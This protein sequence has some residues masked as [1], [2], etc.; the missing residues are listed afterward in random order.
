MKLSFSTLMCMN[1]NASQLL[2]LINTTGMDAAEIRTN[3]DG[4]FVYLPDLPV[5]DIASGINVTGYS[6]SALKTA[7]N[8]LHKID[9]TN[10]KSIRIFLGNDFCRTDENKMLLFI[11][12]LCAM[13][14]KFG[15][16]IWIETHEQY[17]T[18]AKVRNMIDMA[19]CD[20]LFAVWDFCHSL[21]YGETLEQTYNYIGQFI[22]HVHVKDALL[23]S[24]KIKNMLLGEGEIPIKQA[25]D[26]LLR[27]GYDGYFS[28]EWEA[29]W[30]KSLRER[31]KFTPE[32]LLL[33]YKSF[34]NGLFA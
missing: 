18:G 27:N 3:T 6:E 7:E 15:K 28:F 16:E 4:S 30:D 33:K 25:V 10:I 8:I 20:N 26:I 29:H 14:K 5:S 31:Y 19:E 13:Y 34:M 11:K 1:Y 17:S 21:Q 22:R 2:S 9:G 24:A 32:Q 23:T 12:E